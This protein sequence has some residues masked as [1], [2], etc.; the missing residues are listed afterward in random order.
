MHTTPTRLDNAHSDPDRSITD[1]VAAIE[2]E[3]AD[4]E[5][6]VVKGGRVHCS[7]CDLVYQARQMTVL[8]IR[9]QEGKSDPSEMSAVVKL[10]CQHCRSEGALVVGFGPSASAEDQAVLLALQPEAGHLAERG[11]QPAL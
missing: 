5:F 8:E 7:G 10:K 1:D 2:D 4:A 3:G 11:P 6:A 9:R